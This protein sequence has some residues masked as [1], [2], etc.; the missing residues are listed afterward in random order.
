VGAAALSLSGFNGT[1]NGTSGG[2]PSSGGIQTMSISLDPTDDPLVFYVSIYPQRINSVI[3]TITST[4]PPGA[5]IFL[6]NNE[7]ALANATTPAELAKAISQ[8]STGNV[9]LPAVCMPGSTP[10]NATNITIT[11][12]EA[13]QET[14]YTGDTNNYDPTTGIDP[15]S[16]TYNFTDN[17]D[18]RVKVTLSSKQYLPPGCL[19]QFSLN[20]T[21]FF[22]TG[23]RRLLQS[24]SAPVIWNLSQGTSQSAS[25]KEYYPYSSTDQ[26]KISSAQSTASTTRIITQVGAAIDAVLN[27]AAGGLAVTAQNYDLFGVV[28][29]LNITYPANI[30]ALFATLQA[31]PVSM[32]FFPNV[33][34]PI[35]RDQ[36]IDVP[37]VAPGDFPIYNIKPWIMDNFGAE[38]FQFLIMLAIAVI[39]ILI[40]RYVAPKLFTKKPAPKIVTIVAPLLYHLIVWNTI[41][42]FCMTNYFKVVMYIMINFYTGV[43]N[44]PWQIFN[45]FMNVVMLLV[46]CSPIFTVVMT[47][48]YFKR[49][50]KYK[51]KHPELKD[52]LEGKES[53]EPETALALKAKEKQKEIENP[54][55]VD[56]AKE[57]GKEGAVDPVRIEYEIYKADKKQKEEEDKDTIVD[58]EALIKSYKRVRF[59]QAYYASFNL[60]RGF[61]VFGVAVWGNQ[62]PYGC[63]CTYLAV[64]SFM[65]LF[66][67]I[68]R[69]FQS[70]KDNICQIGCEILNIIFYAMAT[71]LTQTP[72]SQVTTRN[73]IGFAMIAVNSTLYI[74]M[75]IMSWVQNFITGYFAVKSGKL[76]W[77]FRKYRAE[78][79]AKEKKEAEEKKKKEEEDKKNGKT[80]DKDKKSD[81]EEKNKL[82]EGDIELVVNTNGNNNRDNEG[83]HGA[84]SHNDVELDTGLAERENHLGNQYSFKTNKLSDAQRIH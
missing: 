66:L 4:N 75:L 26:D 22:D 16:Y 70:W 79:E 46:L 17:G 81:D 78:D 6:A 68:V 45:M 8:N 53:A 69:P 55:N 36:Q 3:A 28:R 60:F 58:L 64:T 61:I 29:F 12:A 7:T 21:Y 41:I 31:Q 2:D 5:T 23:S 44:T 62:N 72:L 10:E 51:E 24:T 1:S 65:L 67:I 50:D 15:T 82:K 25:M 39:F 11:P 32:T 59:Y 54:D 49:L 13:D 20:Q 57:G 34:A 9:T 27:F 74:W 52:K 33:F 83:K 14:Q 38:V 47:R 80:S 48:I 42:T 71:S 37:V 40:K 73:N 35:Q 18:H 84:I 30:Q 77:K 56:N 76:W 43:K 19:L 63:G